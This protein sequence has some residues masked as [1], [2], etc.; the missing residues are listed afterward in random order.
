MLA[1][2]NELEELWT[3]SAY[4]IIVHCFSRY[5]HNSP[6]ISIS[7]ILKQQI[8]TK[9]KSEANIKNRCKEQ[10]NLRFQHKILHKDVDQR[11]R[12]IFSL[13][14][15]THA[16]ICGVTELSFCECGKMMHQMD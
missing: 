1:N 7:N 8:K 5:M 2:S 12:S 11:K 6:N 14:M 13:C 9:M 3:V 10:S 15:K 4:T 16:S